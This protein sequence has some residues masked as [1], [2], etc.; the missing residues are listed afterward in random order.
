MFTVREEQIMNTAMNQL[1]APISVTS[2]EEG[3]DLSLYRF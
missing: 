3:R 1:S 2:Q